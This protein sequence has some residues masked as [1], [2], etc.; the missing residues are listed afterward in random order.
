MRPRGTGNS[1]M[2]IR[3]YL[4]PTV[5]LAAFFAASCSSFYS[6]DNHADEV[7]PENS[8]PAGV[9]PA[10]R[11]PFG[12]PSSAKA[13]PSDPD[14]Y[15]VVKS[16]FILSYNDRRGTANWVAWQTT[17]ADLG[18][19]LARGDFQPDASLPSNFRRITPNDYSGSGYDRGHLVPSAD[20]FADGAVNAETFQMSNIVPQARSLNQFPWEKLESY[21]RSL[22]RRGFTL[23]TYA[24][25]YGDLG[26]SRN[27]VVIPARCWKVIVVLPPG[28][29][30]ADI[31]PETRIIAVDMPNVDSLRRRSWREFRTSVRSIEQATGYDLLSTL[32]AAL[33]EKLETS[34]DR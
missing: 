13:N 14:N 21:S 24:G 7:R 18:E 16:T 22:V 15:L 10:E 32:S 33:Q 8:A 5:L 2:R 6:S 17:K 30:A 11:L 27:K 29:T 9:L 20:R 12:N 19:R 1:W 34:V 3:L 26:T 31:G 28:K 23:F 4:L 25:V